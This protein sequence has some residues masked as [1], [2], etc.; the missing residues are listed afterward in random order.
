MLQNYI[1]I[2]FR[3]LTKNKVY[4]L[5]NIFGF[6]I[7]LT[8]TLL[9]LLWVNDERTFD[10][11]MPKYDRVFRLMTRATY[12]G[13]VNVWNA[14]PIPSVEAIKELSNEVVDI[15]IT[16]WGSDH[17]LAI[18]GRQDRSGVKKHGH[19]A[20]EAFLPMFGNKMIQ[21]DAKMALNDLKSIVLTESTAKML[22]GNEDPMDKTVRFDDNEEL[23]VTGVVEDV[24]EN[25]SV[26]FDFLVSFKLFENEP[27]VKRAKDRWDFHSWPIY[28]EL[29]DKAD[30]AVVVSKIFDLPAK[31]GQTEIKKEFFLH[32]LSRW[33]LYSKFENGEETGGMIEYVRT[34]AIIAGLVLFIACVNFMNLATARAEK[35]A[36]EVG[37]RKSVGSR[38]SDLMSQF[39]WESIVTTFIAC[40]V[41]MLFA[42]ILL[43]FYNELVSKAAV[44]TLHI[45]EVYCGMCGDDF[46]CWY[47]GR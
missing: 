6:A 4:S 34:F 9:I 14:N 3:T 25:S 2:A 19:Y 26:K 24:P 17:L 33:H 47:F 1:R 28:V 22:F 38:R 29:R 45:V 46:R 32:P 13:S 15:A 7:G 36:V 20:N 43:P 37:V 23:K 44:D 40:I 41:G 21:G 18:N 30:A 10:A 35:R 16:D 11:W 39:I 42:Q 27:W 12:G 5:I 8:C 31:H